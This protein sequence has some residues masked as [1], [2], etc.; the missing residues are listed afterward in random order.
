MLT[1]V[2]EL[3]KAPQV[4]ICHLNAQDEIEQENYGYDQRLSGLV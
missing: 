2:I 3:P 1:Y 4:D